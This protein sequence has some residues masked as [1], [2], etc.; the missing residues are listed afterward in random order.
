METIVIQS[1]IIAQN[2]KHLSSSHTTT[3]LKKNY[4]CKNQNESHK[5]DSHK[6]RRPTRDIKCEF[7]ILEF[8]IHHKSKENCQVINSIKTKTLIGNVATQEGMP[9]YFGINFRFQVHILTFQY[10]LLNLIQYYSRCFF[11]VKNIET[12]C[13]YLASQNP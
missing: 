9:D 6:D 12:I 1:S 11:F 3:H 2:F 4:T 8:Q 5:N 10:T 7:Q 13:I